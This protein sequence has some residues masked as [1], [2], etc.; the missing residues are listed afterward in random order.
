MNNF[1]TNPEKL[2]NWKTPRKNAIKA[3]GS[4]LFF[5]KSYN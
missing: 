4:I 1:S 5:K 2:K 3:Y